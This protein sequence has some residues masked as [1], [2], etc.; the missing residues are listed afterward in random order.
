MK[1]E[2]RSVRP[3]GKALDQCL[4]REINLADLDAKAGGR[5]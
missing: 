4:P 5:L 2:N 1:V 3:E